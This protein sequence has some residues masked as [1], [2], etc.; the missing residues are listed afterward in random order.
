MVNLDELMRLRKAATPGPWHI[1]DYTVVC[2]AHGRAVADTYLESFTEKRNEANADYI[3][4]ACNVVP[5]LV[6]RIRD[7]ERLCEQQQHRLDLKSTI[8]AELEERHD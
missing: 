4:A 6:S 8:I 1:E 2:N 5:Y 3:V 7:L